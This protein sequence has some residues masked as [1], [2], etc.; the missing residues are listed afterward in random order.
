MPSCKSLLSLMLCDPLS[1][2]Q[3][4]Y[5]MSS[6]HHLPLLHK[7]QLLPS[8]LLCCTNHT[9]MYN[10]LLPLEYQSE[11]SMELYL[12]LQKPVH[13]AHSTS[14]RL[15]SSHN[16]SWMQHLQQ[17]HQYL[18]VLLSYNAEQLKLS[19][20][21]CSKKQHGY[22]PDQKNHCKEHLRL[23]VLYDLLPEHQVLKDLQSPPSHFLYKSYRFPVHRC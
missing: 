8:C 23:T 1:H 5:P 13:D 19:L 3:S 11:K 9:S 4:L 20:L 14:H 12:L 21:Q 2:W 18:P 22:L 7:L 16:L 17:T 10:C 6:H 15:L